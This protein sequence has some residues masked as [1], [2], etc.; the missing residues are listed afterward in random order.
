MTLREQLRAA[1]IDSGLTLDQLRGRAG[2][3]MSIVSLSRKLSGAQTLSVGECE[4][5]AAALGVVASTPAA[6]SRKR[7]ERSRA[8]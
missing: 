6:P 2:L 7:R 8:A 4:A 1:W 5:L 3:Q